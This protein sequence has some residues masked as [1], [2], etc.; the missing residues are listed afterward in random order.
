M[1]FPYSTDAPVYYWP[2]VTVGMIVV[3]VIAFVLSAAHPEEAHSLMLEIGNGLHPIQ[4][5]TTNFLHAGVMHLL[6]NMIS[7]W[8]FGLIVEG[9]LGP[10]KSLLVY[11]GIGVIYGAT[12]QTLTL[13]SDETYCLGASA[14]V[15]GLMA[16]SL[17]WAP[18]N[19]MHCFLLIYVRPFFFEVRVKVLVGLLVGL[20]I[21][22]VTLSHGELSSEYLHTVGAVVGFILGIVLLKTGQVDCEHWDIFSVWAG[23]HQMTPEERAAL[24][25]KTRKGKRLEAE[26]L[27]QRQENV[28]KRERMLLEE[29]RLALRENK[30]IPA[31]IIN[32]RM[33]REF[34]G[35]LLP[36]NDLLLLIKLL[37]DARCWEETMVAMREYLDHYTE[38]ASLIRLKLARLLV[39]QHRPREAFKEL[40]QVD[41]ATLNERQVAFFNE[42]YEK[43]RKMQRSKAY[44]LA[45]D[46]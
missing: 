28:Q 42:F 41:P 5:L 35:W 34:P 10:W 38:K 30:P 26:R 14:I 20:Q 2:I 15:Y 13:G 37:F 33:S 36:E 43:L 25:R 4:W 7:L 24:E 22:T 23:R 46:A 6:G 32:Q 21:A 40:A 31:Y 11:L 18:E 19:M 9:K 3:N 12:V 27:Q 45:D 1:F 16:M 17:I 8:A 29:I 44:E 39:D